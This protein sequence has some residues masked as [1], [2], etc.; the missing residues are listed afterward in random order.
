[1][2][3]F[4]R[5]VSIIILCMMFT[6]CGATKL[7]DAFSEDK[8]KTSV[9]TVIDNLNNEKYDEVIATGSQDLKSKLTAEKLKESWEMMKNKLGKFESIN[10]EAF[11]G[12]DD[13]AVVIVN[14]KYEKGNVQFTISYND[15]M[16]MIGIYMK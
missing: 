11:V 6:G 15:K 13:S 3:P 1:M 8:L 14:A 2:R 16:E 5:I 7:S 9:E 10:K 12:K 4:I